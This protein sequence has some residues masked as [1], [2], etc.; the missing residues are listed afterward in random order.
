MRETGTRLSLDGL[1]LFLSSIDRVASGGGDDAQ[2]AAGQGGI[3]KGGEVQGQGPLSQKAN[4]SSSDALASLSSS[5]SNDHEAETLLQ[6]PRSLPSTRLA[7]PETEAFP[8]DVL[9]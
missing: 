5:G 8:G 4:G 1:F 2:A 7:A 6:P 3:D 9:A